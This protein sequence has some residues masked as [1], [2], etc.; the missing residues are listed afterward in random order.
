MKLGKQRKGQTRSTVMTWKR[1]IWGV[2]AGVA[3][4]SAALGVWSLALAYLSTHPL[5]RR[6]R[7]TPE[8]HELPF[9]EVTFL[10]KDEVRLSGWFIPSPK[11]LGGIILCHGF[12]NNRWEMMHW[13]RLLA[14]QGYHLLLFDFR[15]LGHSEGD[16]CSIGY[17][18]TGDLLGA[19]DYFTSRP[20]MRDLPLGVFG[21]SMGGAVA[22]MATAQDERIAA[23]ATHGAYANLERALAQRCRMYL[24]PLGP[25][26]HKPTAWWGRRWFPLDPSEVSP[27]NAVPHIAPRPL[28]LFHG[29]R[30]LIVNPNDACALYEAAKEPKQLQWLPNSWHASI[31]PQDQA[32][33]EATLTEFFA[34]HLTQRPGLL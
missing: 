16:L 24:G 10:S 8:E 15:A 12:P 13:A 2:G 20:E 23:V 32:A 18:E 22:L 21:L 25:A 34:K 9:E 30:D 14:P 4:G 31:N 3:L 1:I 19:V 11:A 7:S 17:Y 29:S 26:M 6:L 5:R 27:L 28:L 33:Y